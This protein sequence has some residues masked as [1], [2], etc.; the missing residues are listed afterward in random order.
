[1]E[2]T[3]TLAAPESRS[4][5]ITPTVE[6]GEDLAKVGAAETTATINYFRYGHSAPGR[7][8]RCYWH[9]GT[10]TDVDRAFVDNLQGNDVE[11]LRRASGIKHLE[12]HLLNS[13][14]ERVTLVDTPGTCAV[15]DE[16]VQR[17]A[18]FLALARPL[19]ERHNDETE[20]L[21][22]EADAVIYLVGQVARA[23]DQALLDEFRNVT[24]GRS[25][26]LNALGVL[27]KID[28]HLE[29]LDRRH[30]LADK[31]AAQFKTSLNT[32]VPISAGMQRAV[33][34]LREQGTTGIADFVATLQ[35]IP[36][37]R[38]DKLLASE[39]FFREL[40]TEDCPV[41]AAEREQMLGSESRR[42]VSRKSSN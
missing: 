16:H 4:T 28:L 20:R 14:L 33:D 2:S 13:Y 38:L 26:A 31:I 25:R 10:F 3:Q 19:G 29:I 35:R 24:R 6:L 7:P 1:L 5:G 22:G 34:R 17:T 42:H 30:E 36:S 27:A 18:E 41:S 39:E 15:V 11:T 40:E 9:N 8:V 12:Y 21:G 23:T 32:V 37:H